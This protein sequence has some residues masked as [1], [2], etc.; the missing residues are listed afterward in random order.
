MPGSQY[1]LEIIDDANQKVTSTS[2][3]VNVLLPSYE[4]AFLNVNEWMYPIVGKPVTV[5]WSPSN[6]TT[7]SIQVTSGMVPSAP[8][9]V[10]IA[11]K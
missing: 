11:S 9:S 7:I 5:Q 3:T 8:N 2:P 1:T 4:T 6:A 10:Y